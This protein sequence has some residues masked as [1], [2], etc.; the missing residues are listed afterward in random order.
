MAGYRAPAAP[1][2]YLSTLQEQSSQMRLKLPIEVEVEI[3]LE[4]DV[5]V[6]VAVEV[7]V[8]VDFEPEVEAGFEGTKK[9]FKS[10]T[11]FAEGGP[12]P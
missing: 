7:E 11:H 12:A 2:R 5:A 3:Q 9:R 10:C 4:V 8:H 6:E 1:P